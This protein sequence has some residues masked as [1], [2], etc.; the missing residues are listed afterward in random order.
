MDERTAK[1]IHGAEVALEYAKGLGAHRQRYAAAM[2]LQL[3]ALKTQVNAI[4]ERTVALV[5]DLQ[6]QPEGENQHY[7]EIRALY[8]AQTQLEKAANQ[9]QRAVEELGT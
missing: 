8:S 3:T 9:I 7:A 6:Q 1:R 5:E 4:G 2:K